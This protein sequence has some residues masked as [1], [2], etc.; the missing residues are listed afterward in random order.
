MP[1]SSK[2]APPDEVR[3]RPLVIATGNPGKLR[4][5]RALLAGLPFE[6]VAQTDLGVPSVAETG[7]TFLDNA[8][9]KARHAAALTRC[10]AL[11]DDSGLEVDALDGAPGVHSARYAGSGASDAAN[12]AKLLAALHG[13]PMTE[14]H[15]RFRCV[16]VFIDGPHA[17]A[18]LVSE[19]VWPGLIV[20]SPRG[21]G[22]FGY[23]PHFWLPELAMTAAEMAPDEKNRRSHRAMALGAMQRLLTARARPVLRQ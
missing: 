17:A 12:N 8:L 23:D 16:L 11:A 3:R 14:R 5:L 18:P 4:E 13:V 20:D 6:L 10:A 15:A 1:H 19:G 21:A 9:I 7:R 2:H 22:G